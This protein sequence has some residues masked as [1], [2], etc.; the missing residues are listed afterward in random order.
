[1]VTKI[2]ASESRNSR[3]NVQV[4]I[5]NKNINYNWT[6]VRIYQYTHLEE[7]REAYNILDKENDE[8]QNK[9]KK[10]CLKVK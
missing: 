2:D 3:T 7:I 1:M 5:L 4:K 10:K 9:T 6:R 8:K